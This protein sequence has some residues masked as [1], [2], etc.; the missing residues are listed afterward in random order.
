[1]PTHRQLTC[2]LAIAMA[3]AIAAQPGMA[4]ERKDKDK[5][6]KQ[7][8]IVETRISAPKRIGDF[9]LEQSAYDPAAK[10]AGASFRYLLPQHP[11]IRFD[12]F[13]YPAGE[14]PADVALKSGMKNF[15]ESFDAGVKMKYYNDLEIVDTVAFDILPKN[16]EPATQDKKNATSTDVSREA[17]ARSDAAFLAALAPKPLAGKRIDLRY[18]FNMED[19]GDMVPM[20]SRG[21]LFYKQLYFFKGRI[22]VAESRM[23]RATYET[24]SDRAMRE[25]V[26]AIQATNIGGCA[27]K[28]IA[29]S[30]DE[31]HRNKD[32]LTMHVLGALT[33]RADQNC[34]VSIEDARRTQTDLD[35]KN[36][37]VVT[38][39]YDAK[40][41]GGP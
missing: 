30:L 1:M 9:V 2:M 16:F 41:W 18:K 19:T 10:Y 36:A 21:Y 6:E 7:P 37:E 33:S 8:F 22:S 34:Y 31:L 15:V 23:D 13:V 3:L 27:R 28:P 29:F 26:P 24:L 40:D 5:E 38:I 35:E 11:E 14:M 12:L 39:E 17:D 32:D 20:R 4:K 25:L